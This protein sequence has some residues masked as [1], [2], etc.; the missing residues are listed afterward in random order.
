MTLVHDLVTAVRT[1][2][3]V[4]ASIVR[5]AVV[6]AVVAVLDAIV[7]VAVATSRLLA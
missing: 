5:I 4:E 1:L 3:A 6:G 2:F 7:D